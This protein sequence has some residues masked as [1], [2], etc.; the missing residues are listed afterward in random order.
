LSLGLEEVAAAGARTAEYMRKWL[1][2]NDSWM[3]QLKNVLRG[4]YD[5][6]A[7]NVPW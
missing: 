3:K 6:A 5:V 1:R 4:I 7:Q 2:Q